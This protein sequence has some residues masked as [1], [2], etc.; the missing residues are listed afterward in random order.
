MGVSFLVVGLAVV[1]T[2]L[3][4]MMWPSNDAVMSV[5]LK[6]TSTMGER[7]TLLVTKNYM[8]CEKRN[9]KCLTEAL[10]R[11]HFTHFLFIN[12]AQH[13]ASMVKYP[14]SQLDPNTNYYVL[15]RRGDAWVYRAPILLSRIGLEMC[16]F[17]GHSLKCPSHMNFAPI[18]DIVV[19]EPLYSDARLETEE[20]QPYPVQ[21]GKMYE[22]IKNVTEALYQ[23]E[24]EKEFLFYATYR[25]AVIKMDK[26]LFLK[27]YALNPL[28]REPLYYLARMER[29][30]NNITQCLMY[31]Q[32]GLAIAYGDL[33][34]D[35]LYIEHNIYEW[36]LDEQYAECLYFAGKK[37]LAKRYWDHL[38]QN[39][40]QLP[41]D[42]RM[43]IFSNSN[44]NK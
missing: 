29:T 12:E 7:G 30:Q 24:Q 21:L 11:R 34:G 31:C 9:K 40:P 8:P 23:Y 28:R 5:I 25:R 13:V 36:A 18:D 19:Y 27:A 32:A 42:A 15:V 1:A 4:V 33:D 2:L 41:P 3:A 43:R 16:M 14:L 20:T 39:Q 6:E 22:E 44:L 26:E 17:R 35:E 10:Q 37:D 38:L